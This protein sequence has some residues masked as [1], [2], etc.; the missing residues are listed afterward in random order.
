MSNRCRR[1]VGVSAALLVI[2]SPALSGAADI[3]T[4]KLL[5]KDNANAAKRQIGLLSKDTGVVF[6][7]GDAPDANGASFHAYSATDDFCVILGPGTLSS[8]TGWKN[9]G[10]S[11]KYSNKTTKNSAQIKNGKLLVKIK[12]NDTYTLADNGTQGAVNV[13][14]QFGTG[15]RYCMRCSTP[16]KDDA[17]K[18]LAKDC[19]AAACDPE[20]SACSSL[21]PT[22]TT[23]ST[24]TT[25]TTTAPGMVVG[26][27]TA[28]A[29]RF[30]YNLTLGLAGA[31][32]ACNTSFPGSHACTLAG[33]QNTPPASLVGLK[34]TSNMTVASFWAIDPAADPVTAQCF[35][36]VGFNPN[37]QPGHNWEYGTAHTL[38]RGQKVALDTNSGALGPLVTGVQCNFAPN[39]WVGCCQ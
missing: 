16:K 35:D 34:D 17:S 33:L 4:K 27:L 22:T 30:N 8:G 14:V 36:D 13:Q 31:D 23:T 26:S 29:G 18:F 10:S 2:A 15:T 25:T 39:N 11:W 5:I 7:A 19:A 24:S 20:P 3:S 6:S 9:T 28:T 32:A 21:V 38:S 12:S 37:T 1:L